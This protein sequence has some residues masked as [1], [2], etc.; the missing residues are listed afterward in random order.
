MGKTSFMYS[1][2]HEHSSFNNLL[3]EK[4]YAFLH[5]NI[6]IHRISVYEWERSMLCVLLS[7]SYLLWRKPLWFDSTRLLGLIL[8][9]NSLNI[10]LTARLQIRSFGKDF[11]HSRSIVGKKLLSAFSLWKTMIYFAALF[12]FHCQNKNI[13]FVRPFFFISEGQNWMIIYL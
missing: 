3:G 5:I 10:P 7:R 13:I 8:W 11:S 2:F 6:Y 4:V 9:L 1:I 12:E